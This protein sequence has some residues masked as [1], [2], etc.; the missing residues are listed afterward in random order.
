[1]IHVDCDRCGLDTTLNVRTISVHLLCRAPGASDTMVV[2]EVHLCAPCA[3]ECGDD[4][5]ICERVVAS[6]GLVVMQSAAPALARVMA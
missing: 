4:A 1:M 3:A 6:V 5:A 2:R